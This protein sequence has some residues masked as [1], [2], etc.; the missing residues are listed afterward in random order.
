MKDLEK[1][2]FDALGLVP[3]ITQDAVT[4]EVLMLAYMNKESLEITLRDKKACYFSRSRQELWLKGDTSGNYQEVVSMYYDCD[5]DTI[6][7][8][9]RQIGVAC[10]TGKKT[11]FFNRLDTSTE[12]EQ[13]KYTDPIMT[14]LFEI[15]Q[16]R[17]GQDPKS[18]YVA[19]LYDKGLPEI[20][21]KVK[22]ESGELIEAATKKDNKETIL[23]TAD[24][25]FHVM[26]LL[27][28]KNIDMQNIYDEFRKRFGTSG[29]DEKNSR[30]K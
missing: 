19:S 4:G 1:I 2:K 9:V 18:S 22:E 16:D 7:M 27:S 11:C 29:I 21:G 30:E 26:V 6:L 23:E 25:L 13:S 14:E 10:H 20:L 12:E 28:E 5:G 8:R 15:I 3:A 24:L 17:K